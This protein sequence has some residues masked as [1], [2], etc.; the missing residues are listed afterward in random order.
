MAHDLRYALRT[1]FA[2]RW[3]SAAVVA[4]LALGIGLNTMVFTL[5]Y[6]VLFKAVPV[7]GG[8][9]LVSIVG[10]NTTQ[11]DRNLPMS[12]PDF[13]DYRAQ[14]RSYE[15][16]EATTWE[17]G[18]L[19]EPS[20]PPQAY[21]MQRATSGIF[22][23]LHTQPVLGR[24]FL[25]ADT[26]PGAAPVLVIAYDV[27]QERYGG[28][29]SAIGRQVRVNGQPA[30]IVG[31]MPKGFKFPTGVDL[32]MPLVPTPELNKRDHH[33]LQAFAILKP[34]VTLHQ[35]TVEME[36]IGARISR[37][38]PTTDKD[39]GA[40]VMTFQERFNGGNIR[41]I[42]LLM[43]AAVGFVLLIACADVANM[44]LSRALGR[45]REISIRTALGATR[46]R[47]IRQLLVESLLLSTLGGALGLAIAAGG[48]HWF[49]LSTRWVRPYWI[50]FTMDYAVFGYCAALCV[51]SG[52]L[53][54]MAPALRSSRL[55]VMG[56]LKDGARSVGRQ[57]GA[58]LSAVLVVFQF[59]LTVVLLT[60][61]G[62]FV[63]SLLDRLD[64]NPF[65]PATQI[66]IARIN[67]PD[68]RYKDTDARQH[69][70]DQLLPHLLAI[71]GVTHAAV[72]SDAPGLGAN[73]RQIELEG[74]P[75]ANGSQ[76]PSIALLEQSAGYFDAVHLPLLSGRDFNKTDGTTNHGAAILTRESAA[77]FWP[78]QDPIGKRFRL[79]DEDNKP[80]QWMAVVGVSANLTQELQEND[81][82]P[83][84][85][86]PWAQDGW[87][88]EVLLVD[89]KASTSPAPA[90]RAAVQ[91]LDQDL[92]LSDVY[93]L[94]AAVSRQVWFLRL[95]GSLFIGF[96]LIA[97][98][99]A[100]VGIYAVIAHATSSRT[101]EIG[102][103]MALGATVRNILLLV[104]KR[105]LWQIGAGLVLGIAAALP[106]L[107]VMAS[108]PLGVSRAEP[109]VLLSVATVLACVGVFACWLPARR[110]AALDPVKAIR[111]E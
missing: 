17:Q 76:R 87:S 40:R 26:Q 100:S 23:M 37:Q 77:R 16:F 74:K 35:A 106:L 33:E 7:P 12:L 28:A 5:V 22:A 62:I 13:E 57:R 94:D 10:R 99:M 29:A 31:V 14:A 51:L 25:P 1:I 97:L 60:G 93:R 61:A 46:W 71:P 43:L 34:G 103:R 102:V 109:G 18:V 107:R 69:F 83:L 36:G 55:D 65:I 85:F 108:L 59:A 21:Q 72:V 101:Q 91:S 95:F 3:F 4:T 52:I 48:V 8:A 88:S 45:Q 82:R 105:G 2:H 84:V 56:V 67:L 73:R 19:S 92:P 15:A 49:D 70:Y 81:P 24:G 30:T 68:S 86:V 38:Y 50:Q 75:A 53:F 9:R 78:G 110:A 41:I 42:F 20:T 54:G 104:M 98:L 63:H 6:A 111:Y 11:N 39:V 90:M 47:V 27:W 66:T 79:Y 44:M 58:W 96:A 80:T 32:W 89:S 64:V